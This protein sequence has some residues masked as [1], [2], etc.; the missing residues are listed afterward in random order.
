MKGKKV[1]KMQ[2]LLAVLLAAKLISVPFVEHTEEDVKILGDIMWLENGHTGKTEDDNRQCLILTGAVVVNRMVS[3]EKWFHKRGE[4]TVYDV[5]MAPGQYASSTKSNIGKTDTPD[6]V[7]RI[8]DEILTYGTNVPNYVIY[9]S[10]QKNLGTIWKVIEYKPNE[11]FATNGGHYMEGKD[12]VIE[13]NKQVYLQQCYEEF[14]KQ[15]QKLS[16][17]SAK[18]IFKSLKKIRIKG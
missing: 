9:Q 18:Y 15:M 12:L 13:T 3:D 5:L 7:Y 1:D 2:F 8:A 4:K 10:T 14:K 17:Q 16:K 6:Y 11:Y